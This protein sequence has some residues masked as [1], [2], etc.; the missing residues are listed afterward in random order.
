ML[1]AISP[2][3]TLIAV[4]SYNM[5]RELDLCLQSIK[6]MCAGFDVVLIDDA[7]EEPL[8]HGIIQSHADR[9]NEVFTLPPV[10]KNRTRGRL[11]ENIQRMYEYALSK[12]YR[13]L[14]MVQDDMQLLRPLN[15]RVLSEYDAI[16]SKG[17]HIIQIDPRFL[18]NLG[19]IDILPDIQAYCFAA[20]DYRNSYADVGILSLDR[21]VANDWKFE[22]GE[23]E[24]KI[25]AHERGLRRIFPFTPIMMHVPYPTIYRKGEKV[26]RQS[27]IPIHR[28]KYSYHY[29]S[30]REMSALDARPLSAIPYTRKYLRPK[31]MG[32]AYLRYMF[33]NE[34]RVFS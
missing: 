18:R 8:T 15:Q 4:F 29:L 27:L 12:G 24:L 3:N 33:E 22:I 21:L 5:T 31:G 16:F 30:E 25:K 19:A 17:D 7:S 32:L 13:Y 11:H 34:N 9:L 20:S 1:P 2:K 10:K 14:F 6:D 26:Q 28:G 23:R